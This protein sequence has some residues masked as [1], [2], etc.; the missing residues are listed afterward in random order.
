VQPEDMPRAKPIATRGGI[1]VVL[2]GGDFPATQQEALQAIG[3][4][5][6]KRRQQAAREAGRYIGVGLANFV[7]ATG[8]GPFEP[9]TV[10]IGITGQ[11]E[12]MS[13]AA[14]MGQSTQ[15]MLA[16]VVADQLGIDMQAIAVTT[17]D[18]ARIGI[19]IGGFNSRQTVMAGS[20]AH[21]AAKSLREKLLKVTAHHLQLSEDMLRL[22]GG[23]V[24]RADQP[25]TG[26]EFAAI[27]EMLN[28]L[29]G[30]S[31]PPGVTPGLEA[32]EFFTQD[33]MA[34]T[35]G[36][37]ACEVEVDIET[38]DVK[39]T[40]LVLAHDCGQP[41]NPMLVDGQLM[42]GIAHGLGNALFE[43]MGFDDQAQPVTTNYGEYL[44]VGAG[45][46]PKV[47]LI[48]RVTPTYLNPLGVKGVGEAGVVPTPAA[49]ISA[50]EDALSPFA[51]QISQ[52][53]IA[54]Q[55]IVA[56]IAAAE[57][58]APASVETGLKVPG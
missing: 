53:P 31:L 43:R 58:A 11:V 19:G 57:P 47:K 16:Q 51:V 40:R 2:D 3:W 18:T 35:N 38:G 36:T 34:Y 6:F 12:V 4:A 49:I 52:V 30:Y 28:G 20:S 21:L 24:F 45:E 13:G 29:P 17:G 42:G 7:E 46:M 44:L 33:A 39:L 48:H 25:A 22:E 54:P 23:R 27:A 9:A 37:A 14:A 1:D 55:D 26:L 32:T 56:L 41:I 10:R 15:S 8:R 5:D 50:I